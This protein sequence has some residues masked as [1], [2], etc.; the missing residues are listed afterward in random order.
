MMRA[1]AFFAAIA[2]CASVAVGAQAP[3]GRGQGPGNAAQSPRAA[4][5]IDLTGYWVSLVTDDWRYRMLT[6]PK[7]NV[8]YLPVNA[9]ARRIA[10]EWDPAKDEAAGEQCKGYGAVGVMRLPGRLHITWASDSVLQVDTDAGTQTRRFQFGTASDAV[11]AAS[12]WQ[13]ISSARWVA[14]SNR[15]GGPGPNAAPQGEL[16]VTTTHLRP[17]YIR[18]NGIPHSGDAV[19]TENYV[20]LVDDDGAVYL[21]LTQMVEDP[22][23]LQQPIIRTMLFKQQRDASGWNPTACSAR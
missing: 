11:A 12:S 5:L 13:G 21:A 10:G 15:A 22:I 8:D 19:L 1:R 14:P 7:G 2:L 18:K 3:A 16:R 9:E 23:Y 17:G 6:P 20:R 4:A